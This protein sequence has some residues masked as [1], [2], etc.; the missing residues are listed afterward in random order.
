[1]SKPSSEQS[2]EEGKRKD[3]YL[4][5]ANASRTNQK[6]GGEPVL[7]VSKE[8]LVMKS[9]PE[10]KHETMVRDYEEEVGIAYICKNPR[11]AIVVIY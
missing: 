1:M 10:C 11:C 6:H 9:D 3:E 8:D 7:M 5:Q 2:R 4:E